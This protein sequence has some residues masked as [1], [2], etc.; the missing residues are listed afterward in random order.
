MEFGAEHQFAA[1]AALQKIHEVM[2]TDPDHAK[3]LKATLHEANGNVFIA[4]DGTMTHLEVDGDGDKGLSIF[5]T[6]ADIKG[7]ASLT[8]SHALKPDE[9]WLGI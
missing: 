9:Q 2:K 6:P 7:T 5:D 3:E 4:E 8:Y 1:Q